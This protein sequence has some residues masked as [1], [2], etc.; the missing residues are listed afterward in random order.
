MIYLNVKNTH[1]DEVK[2]NFKGE[3]FFIEAGKT[4]MG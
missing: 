3:D 4:A 1:T 2:L